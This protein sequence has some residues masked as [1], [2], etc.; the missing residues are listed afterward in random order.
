[1]DEALLFIAR[2]WAGLAGAVFGEGFFRKPV[3]L[4]CLDIGIDL[5]VPCVVEIDLTE[6]SEELVLVFFAKFANGG[7]DFGHAHKDIFGGK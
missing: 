6:S 4:A 2:E 7:E 1:M 5:A 3:E